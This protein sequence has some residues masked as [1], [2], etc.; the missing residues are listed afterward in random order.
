MSFKEINKN[1]P[2][3]KLSKITLAVS[4]KYSTTHPMASEQGA[5]KLIKIMYY[6]N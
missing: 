2:E 3:Q 1:A 4:D 6:R 5:I